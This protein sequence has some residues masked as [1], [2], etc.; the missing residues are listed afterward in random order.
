MSRPG[1]GDTAGREAERPSEIPPRGWFAALKRVKAEVKDDNVSLLAAGVAFFAM[2]AIFPAIIALVTIYG[3]VADPN[4]IESQVAEF[5]KSLPAG[6]DQL[7]TSQLTNVVSA[8]RQSLS[9][10]L[11]VSLLA[12]LWSVSSGVQ[13]LVKGLNVV[14]DERE[15]RG[16]VKLRG[17]SLLLTLGA[18]VVAV[19]ALALITVFPSAIDRLGLGQA[20]QVAASVARWVAL[21]VLV[22]LALGVIYRLGP[23]R[24]N[25]RWRWVSIGAVVAL[26]LWLLGSVG[27][28]FYVDNFGKYNQTYGALAAVIIL[29][30]W[31]FLSAF[32]VLLGAEFNAESE[33]QQATDTTTGPER[34][35]GERD[36]EVAD[37][38]LGQGARP[39]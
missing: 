32:A 20:G 13:G 5:A 23:D 12:V 18:I 3:M 29:L 10:G 7:L 1:N 8:G 37:D 30:L 36:A 4:Q 25:P 15:T 34:P 33:R 6:A 2:L 38:T 39:R 31:L 17:L 14:Y 22:L 28:S 27:F 21:A 35:P 19:V 11:V 24:A 16:F 26:V 9:I